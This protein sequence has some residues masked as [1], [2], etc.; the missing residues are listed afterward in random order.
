M[1]TTKRL[2][3]DAVKRLRGAVKTHIKAGIVYKP[4]TGITDDI[5]DAR[6]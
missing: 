4:A 6:D 5:G 2:S 3:G 1:P